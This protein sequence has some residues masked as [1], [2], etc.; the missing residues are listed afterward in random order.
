MTEKKE[1]EPGNHDVTKPESTYLSVPPGLAGLV[2]G[3]MD[4]GVK[5][6]AILL[7]IRHYED[8]RRERRER[9]IRAK[10]GGRR[11]RGR[12]R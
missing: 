1:C 4:M 9:R 11:R 2:S 3:L 10:S 8:A 6:E 5:H 7:V 12:C